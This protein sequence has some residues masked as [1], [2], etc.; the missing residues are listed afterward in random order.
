VPCT[1]EVFGQDG[2]VAGADGNTAVVVGDGNFSFDDEAGFGLR[3][4]PVEAARLTLPDGPGF[5]DL[6]LLFGWFFDLDVFDGYHW[7]AL[8]F[9]RCRC[10]E[11]DRTIAFTARY[12]T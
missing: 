4:D 1:F 2:E 11:I 8:Y 12:Y 9:L 3:I 5:A 10:C 6:D 7:T